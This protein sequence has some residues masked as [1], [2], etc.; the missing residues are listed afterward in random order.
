MAWL[1]AEYREVSPGGVPS[2]LR[3]TPASIWR[4]RDGGWADRAQE[5]LCRVEG[6]P[7]AIHDESLER[8]CILAADHHR[9]DG[10][11]RRPQAKPAPRTPDARPLRGRQSRA[12]TSQHG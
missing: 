7:R 9:G 1:G 8:R 6:M 11:L 12:V 4:A 3:A 2:G 5:P 10:G